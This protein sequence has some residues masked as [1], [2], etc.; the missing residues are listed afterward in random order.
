LESPATFEVVGLFIY[1]E[2]FPPMMA[3]SVI[4]GNKKASDDAAGACEGVSKMARRCRDSKT[5]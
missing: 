3:R 5:S 1:A 2:N 4:V